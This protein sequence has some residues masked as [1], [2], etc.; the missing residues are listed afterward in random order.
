LLFQINEH[1][2]VQRIE[3]SRHWLAFSKHRL[4]AFQGNALLDQMWTY[5]AVLGSSTSSRTARCRTNICCSR[6]A[7]IRNTHQR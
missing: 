5:H 4:N 2:L 1:K 3:V 7:G 6:T